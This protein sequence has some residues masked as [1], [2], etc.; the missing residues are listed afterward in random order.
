MGKFHEM[1]KYLVHIY[2]L[3]NSHKKEQGPILSNRA[4]NINWNKSYLFMLNFPA[5]FIEFSG[6]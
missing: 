5:F 1:G 3:F 4:L 2:Y 6:P